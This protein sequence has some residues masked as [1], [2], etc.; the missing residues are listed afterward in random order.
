MAAGVGRGGACGGVAGWR[1]IPSCPGSPAGLAACGADSRGQQG[2]SLCRSVTDVR[3][4]ASLIYVAVPGLLVWPPRRGLPKW[5]CAT[6][7]P[8]LVVPVGRRHRCRTLLLPERLDPA[9][10]RH[11]VRKR[12]ST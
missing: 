7:I 5:P 8:L 9:G 3:A 11:A 12:S 4:F 1:R 10:D 2:L 6:A